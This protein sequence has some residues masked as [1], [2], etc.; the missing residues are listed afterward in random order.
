MPEPRSLRPV[1]RRRYGPEQ[2]RREDPS[3]FDT[4][5]PTSEEVNRA[6]DRQGMSQRSNFDP[7]LTRMPASGP[8]G[9]AFAQ[10]RGL[11]EAP[12]KDVRYPRTE[13]PRRGISSEALTSVF[14][15]QRPFFVVWQVQDSNLRRHTPTDLQS[16]RRTL[17]TYEDA[18]ASRTLARI[19]PRP[20]TTTAASGRQPGSCSRSTPWRRSTSAGRSGSP[21]HARCAPG[22][23]GRDCRLDTMRAAQLAPVAARWRPAR[24]GATPLQPTRGVRRMSTAARS[25]SM[26]CRS[27]MC[28]WLLASSHQGADPGDQDQRLLASVAE[29][30]R[31]FPG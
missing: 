17:L 22:R 15:G 16:G 31:S 8:G 24:P 13:I 12:V 7:H 2:Q 9:S 18:D 5:T 3:A 28:F 26:V 4:P 11:R 19:R 29:L 25:L 14:A 23:V 1:G 21:C 20:S 10:V 6:Q 30:H 27:L